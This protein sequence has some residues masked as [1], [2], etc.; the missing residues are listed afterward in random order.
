[1]GIVILGFTIIGFFLL[2]ALVVPGQYRLGSSGAFGVG[3]GITAYMLGV[4]HAFD[5]DHIAAID[6]TTRRLMG[7]GERPLSVG[8]FFALG[9]STIVFLL[10]GL[11][12][13]GIRGI[14]GAVQDDG[15]LLHGATGIVGPTVSGV[16][17]IIIGV[18]NLAVLVGILRIFG[19]M[20]QGELREQELEREL[21]SRGFLNRLYGRATRAITKPWQMY[22]LGCL[23]GLG[24]DTAT[25]VALLVI[26]GGAAA[27]GLP[28]YAILC[29]P[30]LFTAGMTLFDTIDGAFMNFAYGW[31]FSEPIRKVFYNLAV[32]ALSVSLALLIGTIELSSVLAD[33]LNLTGEPWESI[34]G[35]D[36]NLIGYAIVGLFVITW[37]SA[38][39][40]WRFGR[41]EERW[42]GQ[43]RSPAA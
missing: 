1:M 37:A 36:L 19:R 2:L 33:R 27:S 30:I 32:T 29:L 7:R 5:A 35:L 18:L 25:E 4:R 28:F 12:A 40:V 17:L 31:A 16:F 38:Y 15:S 23:F 13:I 20:R 24:F 14:G 8:F 43:Q 26:A 3:V 41:I 11:V 22:P 9:H 34:T 39:A 10:G 42:S 21:Q 6:N